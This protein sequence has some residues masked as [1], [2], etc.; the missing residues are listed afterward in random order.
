L[1]ANKQKLSLT[2]I[3]FTGFLIVI[4]ANYV[5]NQPA[6]KVVYHGGAFFACTEFDQSLILNKRL[7]TECGGFGG[8]GGRW[9]RVSWVSPISGSPGKEVIQ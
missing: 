8:L 4:L 5:H 7:R 1:F 3:F 6:T 2:F 9:S